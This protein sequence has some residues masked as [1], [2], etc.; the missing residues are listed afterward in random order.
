MAERGTKTRIPIWVRVPLI[1]TV[2]LIAILV[3]SMLLGAADIGRRPSSHG[4]GGNAMTGHGTSD[5]GGSGAGHVASDDAEMT[6]HGGSPNDG[7]GQ[8]HG[9]GDQ[10]RGH[11]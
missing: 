3:S 10:T 11:G 8:D 7:S 5:V 6:D 4:G 1:V 2:V 9:S